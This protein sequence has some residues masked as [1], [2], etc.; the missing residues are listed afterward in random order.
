MRLVRRPGVSVD[1]FRRRAEP[2]ALSSAPPPGRYDGT[3]R[4]SGH[5]NRSSADRRTRETQSNMSEH[6]DRKTDDTAKLPPP[7]RAQR[8]AAAGFLGAFGLTILTVLLTGLKVGA[9]ATRHLC[10]PR[11]SSRARARPH[12]PGRA[13]GVDAAPPAAPTPTVDEPKTSEDARARTPD[14][15]ATPRSAKRRGE[16]LGSAVERRALTA[17]SSSARPRLG[18]GREDRRSPVAHRRTAPSHARLQC[19]SSLARCTRSTSTGSSARESPR[20]RRCT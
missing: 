17:A 7:T 20:S 19:M 4:F 16:T 10:S 11:R 1:I 6:S 9:P 2:L 18:Y 14:A 13:R 5:R 15:I 12:R 8:L 3:N